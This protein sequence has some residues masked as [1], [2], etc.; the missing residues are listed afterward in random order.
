[1][2]EQEVAAMHEKLEVD[3]DDGTAMNLTTD[4]SL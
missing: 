1:M 4:V 2:F 3:V